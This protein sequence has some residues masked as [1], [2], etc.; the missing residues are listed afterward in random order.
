MTPK[1]TYTFYPCFHIR[2]D[3]FTWATFVCTPLPMLSPDSELSKD[4][5]Y[6]YQWDGMPLACLLRTRRLKGPLTR[7]HGPGRTLLR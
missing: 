7:R 1:A 3:R 4:T 5:M 6:F 2:L